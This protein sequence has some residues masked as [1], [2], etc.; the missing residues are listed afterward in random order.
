MKSISYFLALVLIVPCSSIVKFSDTPKKTVVIGK[1]ENT[2][3]NQRIPTLMTW[4][5]GI[6]LGKQLHDLDEN[7]IFRFEYELDYPTDVRINAG[8]ALFSVIAHP[9]DSIYVTIDANRNL[10]FSGD[11]R[12]TN[13]AIAKYEYA[14][15]HP[16]SEHWGMQ[17]SILKQKNAEKYKSFV[18]SIYQVQHAFA[19]SFVAEEKPNSEAAKW[20]LAQSR[21]M[22]QE[23]L[24]EYAYAYGL[25]STP[26]YYYKSL[27]KYFPS[28]EEDLLN[29][30]LVERLQSVYRFLGV[31]SKIQNDMKENREH[32]VLQK[33]VESINNDFFYQMILVNTVN[34]YYFENGS[35]DIYSNN[36]AF[37]DKH[38]SVPFFRKYIQEKYRETEQKLSMLPE[39]LSD[40]ILK[41]LENTSADSIM[42]TILE[43][44]KGSVIYI[45][46]WGTW[47]GPCLVAM[48]EA[49][50][51]VKRLKDNV[52]FVYLCLD[53]E[54]D[55]WEKTSKIM[56]IAKHNYFLNARQSADMR[57]AFEIQGI[58]FY[59]LI[60]KNGTII[61]KG[62]GLRIYDSL[63][64]NE[65]LEL[66]RK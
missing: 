15:R 64:F 37:F 2:E 61:K 22:Y 7:G 54:Q 12:E 34:Q 49:E 33:I 17:E 60:D 11:R 57:S 1:V 40:G 30:Y 8:G 55:G 42:K 39:E 3:I 24:Q 44:N 4:L 31:Q 5:Y 38:L 58:P 41:R 29:G 36:Q 43:T 19:E 23:L 25:E 6:D 62:N 10:R 51:F 66:S 27:E 52:A 14:I 16:F 48:R 53:S 47:C 35:I 20:I 28:T 65:V 63:V 21:E 46:F 13:Q 9:G 59:M 45:D 32:A 18:D 56:G 50:P 26:D